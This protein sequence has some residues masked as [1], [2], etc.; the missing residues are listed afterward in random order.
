[1]P[2]LINKSKKSVVLKFLISILWDV[3][4]FTIF[5]IPIFGS[6]TD[7]I[8]IPVAVKLWGNYGY[9]AVWEIVDATDQLDAEI[10]T[11]TIIGILTL[12]KDK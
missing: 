3:A 9:I 5:R 7:I 4:D 8:S 11:M 1:M 6:I 12:L 10:P 2:R